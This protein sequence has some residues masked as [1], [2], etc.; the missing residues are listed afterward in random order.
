[1]FFSNSVHVA[2]SRMFLLTSSINFCYFFDF[3]FLVTQFPTQ[4]TFFVLSYHIA[5]LSSRMCLRLFNERDKTYGYACLRMAQSD[6]RHAFSNHRFDPVVS[7]FS[8]SKRMWFFY[9]LYFLRYFFRITEKKIIYKHS[10][11]RKWFR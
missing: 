7:L 3:V 11:P 4:N 5:K 8:F 10:A 1:M 9:L 6:T 2:C